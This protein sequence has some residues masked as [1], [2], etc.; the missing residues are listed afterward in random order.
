MT[1]TNQPVLIAVR[2]D[3]RAEATRASLAEFGMTILPCPVFTYQ[4]A[5]PPP[6]LSRLDYDGIIVTSPR[7]LEM[8]GGFPDSL[9]HLPLCI[10]GAESAARARQLGF[11]NMMG[12]APDAMALINVVLRTFDRPGARLLYPRG[13]Q[14]SVDLKMRLQAYGY[15]VDPVITYQSV[16]LAQLAPAVLASIT[17][18]E[19]AAVALFSAHSA[20]R[21]TELLRSHLREADWRGLNALCLSQRVLESVRHLPWA[22]LDVAATPDMPGM[23]ALLRAQKQWRADDKTGAYAK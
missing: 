22:R 23:L 17:R 9:R 4:P 6:F 7:A 11:T 12:I 18:R 1:Q 19:V 3:D 20:R 13:D 5:T 15:R 8:W 16:P 21:F 2:P 10:V 14:I